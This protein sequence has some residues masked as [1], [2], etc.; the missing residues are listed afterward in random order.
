MF[1][2]FGCN[3]A[4]ASFAVYASLASFASSCYPAWR[5]LMSLVRLGSST[6]PAIRLIGR[7]RELCERRNLVSGRTR[8]GVRRSAEKGAD[9]AC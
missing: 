7:T 2:T 8:D 1:A 4:D 5:L 6:C 3:S 9:S